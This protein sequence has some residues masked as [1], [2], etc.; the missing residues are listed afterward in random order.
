MVPPVSLVLLKHIW[1]ATDK[2]YAHDT[3]LLC[4]FVRFSY[5]KGMRVYAMYPKT[6]SLYP[7]TVID[8]TTYCQGDDH[9]IV[10][11]FDGDEGKFFL[12]EF[13]TCLVKKMKARFK[14]IFKTPNEKQMIH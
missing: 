11:E 1:L 4:T 2:Q 9:M 13:Y 14:P 5:G 12:T 6:T 3:L 10:V 8:N 7:A